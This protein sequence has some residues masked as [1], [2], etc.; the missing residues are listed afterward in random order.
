VIGHVTY[1]TPWFH[2]PIADLTYRTTAAYRRS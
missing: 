2:S 1:I